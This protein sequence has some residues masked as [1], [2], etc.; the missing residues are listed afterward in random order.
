MHQRIVIGPTADAV[1]P[2]LKECELTIPALVSQI[3]KQEDRGHLF[4]QHGTGKELIRNLNQKIEI[5]F[6]QNVFSAAANR[7]P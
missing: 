3:F 6:L 1:E 2:A 5:V 7:S 4:F